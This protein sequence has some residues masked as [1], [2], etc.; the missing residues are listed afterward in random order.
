MSDAAA[1]ANV[2]LNSSNLIGFASVQ[3]A[4]LDAHHR[5]V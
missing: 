4:G 1:W 2:W 3:S 5:P